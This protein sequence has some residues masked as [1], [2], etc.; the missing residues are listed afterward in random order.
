MMGKRL[1]WIRL[2]SVVV[3]EKRRLV[4]SKLDT[5]PDHPIFP[6]PTNDFQKPVKFV[7]SKE[8]V[9]G[10]KKG[11]KPSEE[12]LSEQPQLRACVVQGLVDGLFLV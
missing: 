7:S 9:V 10:E 6:H 2:E 5:N 4:I 1:G 11:E 8:S 3:M 12:K